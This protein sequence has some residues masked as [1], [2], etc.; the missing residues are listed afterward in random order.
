M[1]LGLQFRA[2]AAIA[3]EARVCVIGLGLGSALRAAWRLVPESMCR[4]G[5]GL[6]LPLVLRLRA[7]GA[8][9][10]DKARIRVAVGVSVSVA[11]S[12]PFSA[13]SDVLATVM[14]TSTDVSTVTLSA[15][16]DA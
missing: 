14:V 4:R 2:V 11:C 16:S 8:A 7:G 10:A 3:D 15:A 1:Q 6:G 13:V 12:V 5:F 9:I